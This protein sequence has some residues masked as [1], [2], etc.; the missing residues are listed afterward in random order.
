[1]HI[2]TVR[3][4]LATAAVAAAITTGAGSATAAGLKLEPYEEQAAPVA[5]TQVGEEWTST[6]TSTIS[7]GVNAKVTC[8]LQNTFSALGAAC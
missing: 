2:S 4:A 6:G 7:S 8:L 5:T 1:M 3:A